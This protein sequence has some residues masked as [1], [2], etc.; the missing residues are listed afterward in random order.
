MMNALFLEVKVEYDDN[1]CSGI[2]IHFPRNR[3]AIDGEWVEWWFHWQPCIIHLQPT[4]STQFT[5]PKG[6]HKSSSGSAAKL[7]AT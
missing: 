2:I 5:D 6:M 1:S 4:A 7:P 3:L